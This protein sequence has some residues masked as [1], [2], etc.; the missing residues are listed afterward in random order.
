VSA[1]PAKVKLCKEKERYDREIANYVK[2][3]GIIA[4]AVGGNKANG[5]FITI[6][7]RDDKKQAILMESGLMDLKSLANGGSTSGGT[8]PW[9]G[10]KDATSLK[11]ISKAMATALSK[12]YSKGL[13]WGD[14]KLDN[15]VL[16][17]LGGRVGSTDYTCKAIDLES[18]TVI[19][20]DI[21][22]LSPEV[23]APEVAS[24]ITSSRG[25]SISSKRA[26]DYQLDLSESI[27][28]SHKAD[29]WALGIS[30]LHLHS[31]TP[32]LP[33][34]LNGALEVLGS[35][36]DA[37]DRT[38]GKVDA[39]RALTEKISDNSLKR[40]LTSML[41][42]NPNKRPNINEVLRSVYFLF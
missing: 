24:V 41:D 10:K 28:A 1:K 37:P 36:A 7:D 33:Y 2:V 22:D 17:P 5:N 19:G 20:R 26:G 21:S 25:K 12:I 38:A 3:V 35:L 32:P 39:L 15:F 30:I 34:T 40:L 16:V 13:A 29:I 23:L 27:T 4:S 9:Q 14:L 18:V 31:G 6:Y 8:I 11:R 42:I